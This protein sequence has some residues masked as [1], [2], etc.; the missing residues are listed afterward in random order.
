MINSIR[1]NFNSIAEDGGDD[2]GDDWTEVK[3]FAR[4]TADLQ[5]SKLQ[6]KTSAVEGSSKEMYLEFFNEDGQEA[7][8][9]YMWF[10]RPIKYL[11]TFCDR[12]LYDITAT[13]PTDVEK[14]WSF[15][16]VG[17]MFNV[18][19]NGVLVVE[20]DTFECESHWESQIKQ[21]AVHDLD[22]AS[23]L[24][25]VISQGETND[26]L[27]IYICLLQSFSSSMIKFCGV[28]LRFNVSNHD[29]Y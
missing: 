9:F 5:T 20:F 13:L 8:G 15:S 25:R 24:Y 22:D 4:I 3:T 12:Q 26:V 29:E 11:I 1:F 27:N 28:T 10:G 21:F 17:K 2:G 19:C 14:V 16:K 23:E 7:G 6:I 18:E